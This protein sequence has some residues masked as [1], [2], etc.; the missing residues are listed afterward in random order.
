MDLRRSDCC[1]ASVLHSIDMARS[2]RI[3]RY[4]IIDVCGILSQSQA[5]R[6]DSSTL[7]F[8]FASRFACSHLSGAPKPDIQNMAKLKA[9]GTFSRKWIKRKKPSWEITWKEKVSPHPHRIW[10]LNRQWNDM[11]ENDG[12]M[13]AVCTSRRRIAQWHA[14]RTRSS[15]ARETLSLLGRC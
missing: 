12:S 9:R 2:N 3:I 14:K 8:S 1:K 5:S 4:T 11:V 15:L 7:V 10:P 13:C 6:I